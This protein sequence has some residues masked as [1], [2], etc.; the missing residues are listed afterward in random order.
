MIND[1]A[2]AQARRRRTFWQMAIV[3]A[4]AIWATLPPDELA[5]DND[6]HPIDG[7]A[8][9][10]AFLYGKWFWRRQLD[11]DLAEAA[12]L[13][14]Q[15]AK[16]ELQQGDDRAKV[17]DRMNHLNK[18][19]IRNADRDQRE[20]REE[21]DQRKRLIRLAWLGQCRMAIETTISGEPQPTDD[22]R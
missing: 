13:M 14:A 21:A 19:D 3:L 12:R 1:E 5:L 10:S 4:W 2:K 17:D 15:P 20:Q 7:P 22:S 18:G 16:L 6:C 8:S 11:A 9:V